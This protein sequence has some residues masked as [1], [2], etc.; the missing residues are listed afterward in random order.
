[1]LAMFGISTARTLRISSGSA[2]TGPRR[3]MA[4]RRLGGGVGERPGLGVRQRP[5]LGA[6]GPPGSGQG[7]PVRGGGGAAIL[8]PRRRP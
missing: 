3:S 4:S 7:G 1:M 6:Q 8:W 2:W 5:G